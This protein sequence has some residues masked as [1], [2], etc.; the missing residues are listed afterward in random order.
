VDEALSLNPD[1]VSTACP[2]CLVMLT[3]SVNGKK[4]DGQAKESINVVDVAQLLLDS[5][6]TPAEAPDG[7]TESADEPETEPAQ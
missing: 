5:V 1:I 2:F 6:K 3:D 7:D 4:N